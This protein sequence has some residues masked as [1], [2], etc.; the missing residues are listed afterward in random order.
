MKKERQ[1][2]DKN[3][4]GNGDFLI[5]KSEEDIL[6]DEQVVIDI[7][8]TKTGVPNDCKNIGHVTVKDSD[9]ID[10]L[11][12]AILRMEEY[13]E[14]P[15]LTSLETDKIR[16]RMRSRNYFFGKIFRDKNKTLKQLKIKSGEHLVVQFLE[17]EENLKNNE[18]VL[19]LRK[20]NIKNMD[21]DEFIE[22]IYN[23]DKALPTINHLKSKVSEAIK[24]SQENIAIAK[25]IPHWYDWKYWN[26]D[27]DVPVKSKGGKG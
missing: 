22:F 17:V 23:F 11:K 8:E 24:I 13:R 7:H 2:W 3:H 18:I 26:P 4:I 5:L 25:Y 14:K 15:E 19:L 21:Y 10:E 16:L 20:R 1:H 27:E 6:P 9:T 12:E